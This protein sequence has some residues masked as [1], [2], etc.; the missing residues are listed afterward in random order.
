MLR[1][2]PRRLRR[3]D[4][5]LSVLNATHTTSETLP[6]KVAFYDA[7]L[8]GEVKTGTLEEEKRP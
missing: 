8:G 7:R 2:R 5:N 4:I 3:P 6:G 1:G